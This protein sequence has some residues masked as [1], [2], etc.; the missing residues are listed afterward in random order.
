MGMNVGRAIFILN[1]LSIFS[2]GWV[3]S[4]FCLV[5]ILWFVPQW[6]LVVEVSQ[7]NIL[8]G[9]GGGAYY[10]VGCHKCGY[11]VEGIII[12]AVIVDVKDSGLAIGAR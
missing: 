10:W 11:V 9:H 8:D 6:V 4:R 2:S 12:F 1:L 7:P 3:R 5:K